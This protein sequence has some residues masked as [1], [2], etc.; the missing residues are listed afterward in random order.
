MTQ[1]SVADDDFGWVDTDFK[2]VG[3]PMLEY[4][5]SLPNAGFETH[6]YSCMLRD[7]CHERCLASA[8]WAHERGAQWPDFIYKSDYQRHRLR[9]W[10]PTY[11]K[12]GPIWPE[13]IRAWA[14][15]V[16][17]DTIVG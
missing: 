3:V 2:T 14:L 9:A 4:L 11:K 15:S 8:Q 1:L 17:C 13:N 16:G 7:C 10:K 5:T 12:F 6:H